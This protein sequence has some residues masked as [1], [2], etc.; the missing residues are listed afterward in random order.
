MNPELQQRIA[1][2]NTLALTVALATV[3]GCER[4]PERRMKTWSEIDR[5]AQAD[6]RPMSSSIRTVIIDGCQYFEF[7]M[8]DGLSHV[9]THKGNCTNTLHKTQ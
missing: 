1:A 8:D 2:I 3:L 7:K 9:Y 4:K 5:L 6:G